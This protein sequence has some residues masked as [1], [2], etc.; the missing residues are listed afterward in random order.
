MRAFTFSLSLILTSTLLTADTIRDFWFNGAEISRYELSQAQYGENHPGH[1]EFI[2][3]TEPFLIDKQV[4][5][6]SGP[7]DSTDVLKLNA[8][9]TFNTGIYSYRT[10][11]S[12][13]WSENQPED[14]DKRKQLGLAPI[15]D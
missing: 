1:V 2:F 13:Y 8:L 9:R 6:E 3:I 4:K 7:G 15:A 10:M 14:R 11:N 12:N 5:H